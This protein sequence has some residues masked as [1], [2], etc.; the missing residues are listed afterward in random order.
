VGNTINISGLAAGAING[1]TASGSFT[2]QANH[3]VWSATV[4]Q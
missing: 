1:T 3:G 4:C 2:F